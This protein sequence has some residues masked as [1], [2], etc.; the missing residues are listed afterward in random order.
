MSRSEP[1]ILLFRASLMGGA[2]RGLACPALSSRAPL[3]W[4]IVGLILQ[5]FWPAA[6]TVALEMQGCRHSVQIRPALGVCQQRL[7]SRQMMNLS[8]C[9]QPANVTLPGTGTSCCVSYAGTS[10]RNI[11]SRCWAGQ[12]GRCHRPRQLGDELSR[13]SLQLISGSGLQRI[14]MLRMPTNFDS[15]MHGWKP[16]SRVCRRATTEPGFFKLAAN[17][18]Q[19]TTSC[20]NA[21]SQNWCWL[22]ER[23]WMKPSCT[24]WLRSW[25]ACRHRC[26]TMT[27]SRPSCRG[28]R[29][30]L[31]CIFRSGSRILSGCSTWHCLPRPPCH[32]APKCLQRR[33]SSLVHQHHPPRRPADDLNNNTRLDCPGPNSGSS[34]IPST[35]CGTGFA[36]DTRVGSN[37][38]RSLPTAPVSLPFVFPWRAKHYDP[39]LHWIPCQARGPVTTCSHISHIC[40]HSFGTVSHFMTALT[41]RQSAT[42]ESTRTLLDDSRQ[43]NRDAV[44]ALGALLSLLALLCA[45]ESITRACSQA[46]GTRRCT[47]GLYRRR[48]C[49]SCLEW[50]AGIVREASQV[51]GR[52]TA[53]RSTPA[54]ASRTRQTSKT[55][56]HL[57]LPGSIIVYGMVLC[58]LPLVTRSAPTQGPPVPE[59]PPGRAPVYA[60]GQQAIRL[61]TARKRAFRRAQL[62]VLRDGSTVYRGRQHDATS[63]ALQYVGRYTPHRAPK[64]ALQAEHLQT[65]TW[66][67]G[68][69]HA[70]RYEEFM[71]WINSD[72]RRSI[73]LVFIQE[74]HWPESTE[75]S[76]DRWTHIYSGSG[77][78]QGGVMIMINR[79]I[80]EPSQIR[81]AELVA[82]RVLHVRVG[83]DPPVDA[84]CVYQHA[85][86]QAPPACTKP[87]TN[88]DTH[89]A[90]LLARRG[91]VWSSIRT[92]ANAVPQRNSMLIAGDFNA[93]LHHNPPH[94]GSGV[95]GHRAGGH[96]DQRDFQN[97]VISSGLIALNTWGRGG[98][99]AATYLMPQGQGVQIDYMLTR[100]P[101]AGVSR[102]AAS[103]H[104]AQ[105]IHPT[106]CRHVP[107]ACSIPPPCKPKARPV[108]TLT[109][110]K[111]QEVI[112][113]HPHVVSE[114]SRAAAISLQRRCQRSIDACLAEAWHQCVQPVRQGTK[115]VAEKTGISLPR[116][117]DRQTATATV[118]APG[119]RIPCTGVMAY[120]TIIPDHSE[121]SDA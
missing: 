91:Q 110:R 25:L 113:Q 105:I 120:S 29:R 81:F 108:P 43:Q 107:V 78:R 73:H 9:R 49:T 85:W 88:G 69:M 106:G 12:P 71:Q 82:G 121:P 60:H 11:W 77:S 76:N 1:Q 61:T 66:N 100:L 111:V 87:G 20:G 39:I 92:W 63:L 4:M 56:S 14:W 35:E 46:W 42:S 64:P 54:P 21:S 67:C 51:M 102:R 16:S 17:S 101:C 22:F 13:N 34:M 89:K 83:T 94:V 2:A 40:M 90:A 62:R 98:P 75:Y 65:L 53:L 18:A 99:R 36:A 19:A 37:V 97:L 45:S 33:T 104:D 55:P 23:S 70:Q 7:W 44:W 59:L 10:G 27:F 26:G 80:A 119:Q 28:L 32:L 6:L 3:N 52:S 116:V 30:Q 72:E 86:S 57:S 50:R 15:T 47:T 84:L 68:G 93:S 95:Q 118:P 117:L 48:R 5:T 41:L 74:C 109:A 115:P 38:G 8:T 79:S 112:S 31:S 58:N 103:L 24:R 96:P 114:F